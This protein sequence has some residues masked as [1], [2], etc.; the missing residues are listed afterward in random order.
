MISGSQP[1]PSRDAGTSYAPTELSPWKRWKQG[2]PFASGVLGILAGTA[3]LYGPMGLIRFALVPGSTLWA[4]LAVGGMVLII[5]A[6]ILLEPKLSRILGA[7]MIILSLVSL[8]TSLGG[9]VV[10]MLLGI[11]SGGLAVSWEITPMKASSPSVLETSQ[12]LW[13]SVTHPP[14]PSAHEPTESI[15]QTEPEISPHSGSE[16]RPSSEMQRAWVQE[17]NQALLLQNL[18]NDM[19]LAQYPYIRYRIESQEELFPN[20]YQ[21]EIWD[22]RTEQPSLVTTALFWTHTVEKTA[23][24]LAEECTPLIQEVSENV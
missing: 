21:I 8:I 20:S 14:E 19:R 2:R 10:G 23:D 9:L 4:A 15:G 7:F 24:Y 18:S 13:E 6:F 16:P 11:V 3:M 1:I 17:L 22:D 5:G 12:P